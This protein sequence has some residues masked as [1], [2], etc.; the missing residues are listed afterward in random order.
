MRN[1]YNQVLFRIVRHPLPPSSVTRPSSVRQILTCSVPH[2]SRPAV[3][4]PSCVS[5]S[6]ASAEFRSHT[7]VAVGITRP[8]PAHRVSPGSS[9][10][11]GGPRCDRPCQI[12]SQRTGLGQRCAS[13][14]EQVLLKSSR[15]IQVCEDSD[16]Q[17]I[18]RVL[19]V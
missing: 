7:T 12:G 4:T 5:A 10:S 19:F 6:V 13:P 8:K 2:Q 18:G 15:V 17:C 3:L 11:F 14:Q 1:K 16:E 9:R